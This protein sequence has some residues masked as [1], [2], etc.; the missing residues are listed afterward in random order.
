MQSQ[1]AQGE[2]TSFLA[3]AGAASHDLLV[4]ERQNDPSPYE[5]HAGSVI[6][7]TLLT[8]INAD[9]PGTISDRFATT[10]ST[11]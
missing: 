6:P 11:A 4:V 8:G 5:L 2:R 3:S 10:S 9:L 7:A 1:D